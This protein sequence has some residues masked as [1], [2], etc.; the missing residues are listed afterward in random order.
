MRKKLTVG[1]LLFT[2]SIA[3]AWD[4]VDYG[5]GSYVEIEKGHIVQQGETIEIFDHGEA[6]YKEVSVEKIEDS[7][8][9]VIVEVYDSEAEEYRTLEME[10][11]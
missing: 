3:Q 7:G 2:S 1:L 5:S 6:K 11:E 8:R 4:G 9:T 10:K